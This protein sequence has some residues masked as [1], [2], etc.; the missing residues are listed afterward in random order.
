M[1]KDL[2]FVGVCN[3]AG[4]LCNTAGCLIILTDLDTALTPTK[5]AKPTSRGCLIAKLIA[6]FGKVLNPSFCT[7]GIISLA[8]FSPIAPI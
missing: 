6:C 4:C 1:N 7:G 2:Y 8:A 3:T 5:V